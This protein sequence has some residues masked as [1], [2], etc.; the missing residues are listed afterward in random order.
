MKKA[1]FALVVSALISVGPA[2]AADLPSLA[3]PLVIPPAAPASWTGFHVGVNVGG[4]WSDARNVSHGSVD[5]FDDPLWLPGVTFAASATGALR[6]SGGAGFIG[7]GQAGYDHQLGHNLLVGLEADIQALS[8]GAGGGRGAGAA[9]NALTG[10]WATT[11][12]EVRQKIDYIGTARGRIGYLVTPDLL[13]YATGGLAYGGL[14]LS[15]S[16]ASFDQ[17]GFY[18]PG[19]GGASFDDTRVGWTA[20]GGGEWMFA[21]K[22]SASLNY[23]YYDLGSATTIVGPVSGVAFTFNMPPGAIGW[24]YATAVSSRFDGHIVRAGLNYHFD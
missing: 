24:T 8:S 16:Q 4:A 13:A 22:W 9:F 14:R 17:L 12:T 1:G 7:G 10:S 5:L 20:G 21:P 18:G 11:A 6:N 19:A 23:L 2:R 15:A 3:A